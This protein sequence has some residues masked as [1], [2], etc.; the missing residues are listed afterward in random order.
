[1]WGKAALDPFNCV[2]AGPLDTTPRQRNGTQG[3]ASTR[4]VSGHTR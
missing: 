1:M 3:H 2:L 4:S